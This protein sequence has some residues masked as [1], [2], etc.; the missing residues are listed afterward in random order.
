MENE[1]Y[2]IEYDAKLAAIARETFKKHGC[3]DR[4]E[5]LEGR[6]ENM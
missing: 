4:I 5:V 1:I 2:T 6:A 3:D